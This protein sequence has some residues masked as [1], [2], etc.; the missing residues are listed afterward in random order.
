MTL[1]DTNIL[2]DFITRDPVWLAASQEAFVARA[3]VGRMR[4]IDIVYS[5]T[6]ISFRSSVDFDRFLEELG[7]EPMPISRQALF[8]A[9]QAFK[10]YRSQGGQ[11]TSVL[12]DFFIG[13]HAAVE[14][15][16]ILTRDGRSYRSYFPY[17]QVI[18]PE[19]RA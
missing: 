1:V 5:E 16:P 7:V 4:I 2:L 19:R 17:A 14:K 12:P 13:A 10:R 8:L 6:S 11:K 3:S 9:G 15:L 18:E